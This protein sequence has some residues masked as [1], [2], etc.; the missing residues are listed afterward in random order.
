MGKVKINWKIIV[1]LVLVYAICALTA[2]ILPLY[3]LSL[4]FSEPNYNT[5]NFSLQPERGSFLIDPETI[6]ESLENGETDVFTPNLRQVDGEKPT[7]LFTKPI[8]WTQG[9][10][11]MIAGTV[12]QLVWKDTLNGWKLYEMS[13]D[14]KCQD[15]PSGFED[16]FMTYFKTIPPTSEIK[17][18]TVRDFSIDPKY[19]YVEWRGGANYARPIFGWKSIDLEK[20]RINAKDALVIAEENGGKNTRLRYKNDCLI[21]MFL[22]PE[23]YAGWMIWYS[24]EGIIKYKLMIDPFSGRIINN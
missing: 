2:S 4:L 23:R 17:G 16:G 19:K 20:I 22:V 18:Y 13:F 3:A 7:V 9:A 14:L 5:P 24:F 21:Q 8:N 15:N 10:Y 11:L 1:P 6:L 12:N